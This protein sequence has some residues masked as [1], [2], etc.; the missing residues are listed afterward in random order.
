MLSIIPYGA[1]ESIYS[2]TIIDNKHFSLAILLKFFSKH[3][4]I[5]IFFVFKEWLR[6]LLQ[7]QKG[8]ELFFHSSA[9]ISA[10]IENNISAVPFSFVFWSFVAPRLDLYEKAAHTTASHTH[11]MFSANIANNKILPKHC[12]GER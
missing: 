7:K 12:T 8:K 11:W 4:I 5:L 1:I 9:A 10:T 2:E 3:V 6:S